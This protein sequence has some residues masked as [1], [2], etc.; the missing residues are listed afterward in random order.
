[1][2][3]NERE[4]DIKLALFDCLLHW[5]GLFLML[6]IGV[7]IGGA[8][9]FYKY[10]NAGVKNTEA[11]QTKA[12]DYLNEIMAEEEA[13]NKV[14]IK[15]AELATIEQ[16]LALNE[17]LNKTQK[18]RDFFSYDKFD[19]TRVPTREF[20]FSVKADDMKSS[21]D[22][23]NKYVF[24]LKTNDFVKYVRGNTDLNTDYIYDLVKFNISDTSAIDAL[25]LDI[26]STD[27]VCIF[28]VQV[29]YYDED[30]CRILAD[31]VKNYLDEVSK[32][33]KK[34]S[35]KHE[36]LCLNDSFSFNYSTDIL[37][38]IKNA[39]DVAVNTNITIGKNIDGFSDEGKMYYEMRLRELNDKAE[40]ELTDETVEEEESSPSII[41]MVKTCIKFG[42]AGAVGLAFVY[43]GCLV[44]FKYVLSGKIYNGDELSLLYEV[45][46]L[47]NVSAAKENKKAF[48]FIDRLIIKLRDS[49]K[50]KF[51]LEKSLEIAT[52][53]V[54]IA[55]NKNELSEVT[56]IGC[57]LSEIKDIS[58]KLYE[59]LSKDNIS[60]VELDNILYDPETLGKISGNKGAVLLVRLGNTLYDEVAKEIEILK[61]QDVKILGAVTVDM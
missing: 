17:Y 12:E 3:E 8:F 16:T 14:I 24:Y 25:Q 54:R 15:K 5:R 48:G 47:A 29:S 4:I 42:L 43:C 59:K 52:S 10:Y 7:I 22:L 21:T 53:A 56:V 41:P 57:N 58:G 33:L 44:L 60:A 11:E 61:S 31:A 34:E 55:A 49:G 6:I 51:D 40:E 1:M 45:N 37:N 38:L 36:F 2:A 20:I 28:S 23:A 19:Y 32:T 9:G 13:D 27:P 35:V 26:K 18:Q 30:S 50:R 39:N 46:V